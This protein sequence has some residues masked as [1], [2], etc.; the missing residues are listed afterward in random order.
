MWRAHNSR[1][2]CTF[3][4]VMLCRGESFWPYGGGA[5]LEGLLSGRERKTV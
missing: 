5:F 3:E 2:P 1:Y 4:G